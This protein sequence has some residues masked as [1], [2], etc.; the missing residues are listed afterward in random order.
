ME[1]N[2]R[3]YDFWGNKIEYDM[4]GNRKE[5]DNGFNDYWIRN[6]SYIGGDYGKERGMPDEEKYG[7]SYRVIKEYVEKV[8]CLGKKRC[9]KIGGDEYKID[10]FVAMV[11]L[12]LGIGGGIGFIFESFIPSFLAWLCGIAILFGIYYLT[13]F[14]VNK[15]DERDY[16]KIKMDTIEKYL[17]DYEEWQTKMKKADWEEYKK[18][19]DI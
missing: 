1:K 2:Y 10:L 17:Q 8:Y 6:Y 7:L 18:T 11:C 14:I 5:K 3:S 19:H 9:I 12:A 13:H 4:Y 16:K 15:L